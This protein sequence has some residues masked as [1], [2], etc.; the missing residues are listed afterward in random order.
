MKLI[1]INLRKILLIV[2][3]TLM[4]RR[5]NRIHLMISKIVVKLFRI[6]YLHNHITLPRLAAKLAKLKLKTPQIWVALFYFLRRSIH[7]MGS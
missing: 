5:I 1:C 3:Q 7:L 6:Q 2:I 4:V